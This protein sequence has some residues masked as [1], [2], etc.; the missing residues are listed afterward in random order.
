M[1][2]VLI[3]ITSQ[4]GKFA[5][6]ELSVADFYDK[7]PEY[8][9]TAEIKKIAFNKT[10]LPKLYNS[11]LAE[12]RAE[13]CFDFIVF[14]HADVSVRLVDLLMDIEQH[15]DDYD[16]MGLCGCSKLSVSES[17]LNWFTGSRKFPESRWGYVCHGELGDSESFFSRHSPDVKD[18]A[19]ACIDGLCIVFSP[20][21]L[22]SDL[23]FD[24]DFSWDLYDTSL[25]LEA[26]IKHGMR[27]GVLVEKSLHHYSV[28]K[29]ILADKFLQSEIKL[30]CKWG[31]G[32][33]HG[34][35]IEAMWKAQ[36]N[37]LSIT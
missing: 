19:A 20:S 29:S 14:M 1:S 7:W 28:G 36:T 22:K 18:H 31:L 2:N 32:F 13:Q 12:A 16:I 30:R 17:P 15:K 26:Q 27:I 5:I 8:K 4:D 6:D 3:V 23:T 9:D 34:S 25:C 21:A 33:P 24:E 11:I 37:A 35:K 10:P